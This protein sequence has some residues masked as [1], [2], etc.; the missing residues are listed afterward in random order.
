MK[1]G[2]VQEQQVIIY[3]QNLFIINHDAVNTGTVNLVSTQY[4]SEPECYYISN[5]TRASD[6]DDV[7][8]Q[9]QG[10]HTSL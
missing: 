4:Q 3:R 7:R 8:G 5:A 2:I 9:C 1:E 6:R 10:V